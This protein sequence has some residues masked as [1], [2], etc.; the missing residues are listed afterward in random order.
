MC[1]GL[2]VV[3]SGY[4]IFLL[5]REKKHSLFCLKITARLT[6]HYLHISTESVFNIDF[7]KNWRLI[8]LT[9]SPAGNSSSMSSQRRG[10]MHWKKD[11]MSPLADL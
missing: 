7:S 9:L 1:R 6:L 8:L 11:C 2:G 4:L 5:S 3:K 10:E